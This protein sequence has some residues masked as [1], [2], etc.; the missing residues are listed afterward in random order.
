M[1]R[2][3]VRSAESY[4]GNTPE[5]RKI[6]RANLIPGNTWQKKHTK[7]LKLNCWWENADLESKQFIFEGCE[8]GRDIDQ[9]AKD[10]LQEEI[11]LDYWWEKLDIKDKKRIYDLMMD[12]MDKGQKVQILDNVEECLKEKLEL[13][14]VRSK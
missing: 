12:P 7:E 14:K 6:Q 13:E 5:A 2:K 3:S 10:E 11:E 8:K 9:V 4:T 1:V